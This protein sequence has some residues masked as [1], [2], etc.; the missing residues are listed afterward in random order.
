MLG[1]FWVQT[2][3]LRATMY[4]LVLRHPLNA[5]GVWGLQ[6]TIV[7]V[8]V[9]EMTCREPLSVMEIGLSDCVVKQG[10]FLDKLA[11]RRLQ[12]LVPR[13]GD[14]CKMRLGHMCAEVSGKWITSQARQRPQVVEDAKFPIALR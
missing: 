1:Y 6:S 7:A 13:I 4:E 8:C 9:T 14:R 3:R 11:G 2:Y 10:I 12:L 5:C